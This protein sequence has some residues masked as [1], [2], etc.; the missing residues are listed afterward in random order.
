MLGYG[1]LGQYPLG[2]IGTVVAIFH[3]AV[4][5]RWLR[6]AATERIFVYWCRKRRT[7]RQAY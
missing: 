5:T 2:S 3:G 4:G 1:A 6:L 7:P